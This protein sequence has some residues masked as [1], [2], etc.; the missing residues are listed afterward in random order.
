MYS[1]SRHV[2]EQLYVTLCLG[3]DADH[4]NIFHRDA[5]WYTTIKNYVPG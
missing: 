1:D 2:E 3:L 5:K 4:N